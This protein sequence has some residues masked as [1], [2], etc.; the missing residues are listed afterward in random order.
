MKEDGWYSDWY[1]IAIKILSQPIYGGDQF[2]DLQPS[3]LYH[4]D[5]H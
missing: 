5:N 2:E 4:T 3:S 1:C